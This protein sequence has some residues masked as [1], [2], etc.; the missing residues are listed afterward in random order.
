MMIG[1][2]KSERA[3]MSETH[4]RQKAADHVDERRAKLLRGLDLSSGVG[5]E[6]GALCRPFLRREQGEVIYVD[7]TDSDTLRERYKDDPLVDVNRMVEVDAVWGKN[8]LRDA[9]QGRYVDYVVA[10]HVIEH[11]PNLINWLQEI[12]SILKPHGEVRLI[13]PDRRFTFDCAREDTRLADVMLSY[14]NEARIPQPHS[15]LD[16]VLNVVKVGG[17]DI[18]DGRTTRETAEKLHDWQSAL[19]VARDAKENK[20]YHDTHCWTFTPMSFARILSDISATGLIDFACEGFHDTAY[21]AGEFFVSLRRSNDPSH[22]SASWNGMAKAAHSA[23]PGDVLWRTRRLARHLLQR[24]I[25]RSFAEA[26]MVRESGRSHPL[27]ACEPL[28]FPSDFNPEALN[29]ASSHSP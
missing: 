14:L 21:R 4:D 15:L 27:D 23:S 11:V 29:S 1:R 10:S 8:T 16:Y 20:T 24:A 25:G 3:D 13:V 6:I 9:V 22:I 12:S 2:Q 28:P 19:Q 18:W 7:Y 5:V 26:W 17:T